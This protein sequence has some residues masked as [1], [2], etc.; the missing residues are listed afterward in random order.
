MPASKT[1]AAA[2]AAL[3]VVLAGC[4]GSH[5]GVTPD[6]AAQAN[7][8]CTTADREIEALPASGTGLR[9]LAAEAEE[10]VPVLQAELSGL[11]ALTPPP[12][13][14]AQYATALSTT[15]QELSVIQALIVAVRAG[16]DER[17]LELGIR[18]DSV[19]A[20]VQTEMTTLG[21]P[22]CALSVEPRGG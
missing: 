1:I 5:A 22:K 10:E 4:G 14:Q 13:E 21:L 18:G 16:E 2:L 6:F 11:Q 20:T 15:K 9:A 8:I 17:V 7:A 19:I 12:S 3:S